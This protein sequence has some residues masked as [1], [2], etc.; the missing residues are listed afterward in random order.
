MDKFLFELSLLRVVRPHPICN[1]MFKFI[2]LMGKQVGQK[3]KIKARVVSI[4]ADF[5]SLVGVLTI[6]DAIVNV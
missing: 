5:N 1:Y 6:L 4:K 2:I 3:K